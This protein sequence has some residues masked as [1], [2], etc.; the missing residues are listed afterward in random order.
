[1]KE[2]S[3]YHTFLAHLRTFLVQIAL[4]RA[5]IYIEMRWVK[6]SGT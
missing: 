5:N 4:A 6:A 3:I 2:K 1:M